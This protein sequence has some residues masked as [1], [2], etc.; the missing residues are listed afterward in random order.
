MNILIYGSKIFG[1]VV[2]ELVLNLGHHFCGFIDDFDQGVEIIG[3]YD[4]VKKQY[5]NKSYSIAIAIGYKNLLTRWQIYQKVM[6]DGYLVPALIHQDAYV[7]TPHNIANGAIIM[8]R[9][10]VD[11]RAK[12]GELVTIWPGAIVNHDS[13]IS[14]N[15]FLSPGAI[16]C[17][18][19][20]IGE[21]TFVG[22]GAIIVDHQNLPPNSFIKAGRVYFKC[23]I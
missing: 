4:Q 8:A 7:T 10:I 18:S 1:Q 21:N 9:S 12:I 14:A 19:S 3:S 13:T 11:I 6:A 20:Y 15:T 17:G 16:V 2:R 5:S 23:P 22:A